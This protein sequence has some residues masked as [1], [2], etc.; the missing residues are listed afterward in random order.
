ME[1]IEI[2]EEDASLELC[3]LV[4]AYGMTLPEARAY[5][6]EN[7]DKGKGEAIVEREPALNEIGL[8]IGHPTTLEG[9]KEA[10]ANAG[11]EQHPRQKLEK[12]LAN[13][14]AQFLTESDEEEETE[15]E[16]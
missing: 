3:N 9:L 11:L 10:L 14:K 2:I 8:P 15:E 1:N 16:V 6:A 12:T 7:S 13:Y 4:S 5:L